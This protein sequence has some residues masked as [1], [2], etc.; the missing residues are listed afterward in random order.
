MSK[1]DSLVSIIVPVYNAADF[2]HDTIAT[3]LA[4]TYEDWELLFVDDA[5]SDDS[6]KIIKDYRKK[7]KRIKLI[8]NKANS[9]AGVSRNNGVEVASGRYICF[10]DADDLWHPEKLQKQLN[11]V[12]ETGAAF[13]CTGYEFADEHGRPNGKQVIPPATANYRQLLT[14]VTVWTSTTMFDM[15]KLTKQDIRMPNVR[16]G[17]DAATWWQVLKK[18]DYAYGLPE[19]LAYYR[20]TSDTLSAN[21]FKAVQGTWYLYRQV[22]RIS[23]LKSLYYIVCHSINATRR[24]L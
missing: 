5:S 23:L 1:K 24:R 2:L 13:S 19:V 3:V 20:R 11:F 18:V 8:T 15:T 16:I 21:K 7:D 22:E 12:H 17:Q 4:Q 10:L 14:N 9:G 6:V